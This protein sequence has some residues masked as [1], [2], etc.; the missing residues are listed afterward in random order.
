MLIALTF[1]W[2][3]A[4]AHDRGAACLS[5]SLLGSPLPGEAAGHFS[6]EEVWITTYAMKCHGRTAA[7]FLKKPLDSE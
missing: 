4:T 5:F 6:T 7:D 1:L 2:P 3:N